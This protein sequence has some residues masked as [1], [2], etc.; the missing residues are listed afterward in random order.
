[1][2][3]NTIL[4]PVTV[5]LVIFTVVTIVNHIRQSGAETEEVTTATEKAEEST[6]DS[7][8]NSSERYAAQEGALGY[9]RYPGIVS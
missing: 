5:G 9:R 2:R 8:V 1:M 6:D 7:T 4:A 3:L